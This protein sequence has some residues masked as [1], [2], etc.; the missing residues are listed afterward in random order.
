MQ[1][2]IIK[3][4]KI[5]VKLGAYSIHTLHSI[6]RK[7]CIYLNPLLHSVP[8]LARLTKIRIL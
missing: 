6:E 2:K 1:Y 4:C 8:Y 7:N 3:I 5:S